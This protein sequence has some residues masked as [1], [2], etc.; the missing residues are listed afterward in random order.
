ML[1]CFSDIVETKMINFLMNDSLLC[2]F[3]TQKIVF[4]VIQ[5][6]ILITVIEITYLRKLYPRFEVLHDLWILIFKLVCINLYPNDQILMEV[7]RVLRF[8]GIDVL[9]T[10]NSKDFNC[11][12]SHRFIEITLEKLFLK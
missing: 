9:E 4:M 7:N 5:N 6:E 11:E 2:A 8:L 12:L 1:I 3:H 10:L